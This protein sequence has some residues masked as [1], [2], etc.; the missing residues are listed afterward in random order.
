MA[1]CSVV[2]VQ[3]TANQPMERQVF[4][5]NVFFN[6]P[7]GPQLSIPHRLMDM[8]IERNPRVH[9]RLHQDNFYRLNNWT[10]FSELKH[11]FALHSEAFLHPDLTLV[12]RVR[13]AILLSQ[14]HSFSF[15]LTYFSMVSAACGSVSG[16]SVLCHSLYVYPK[17]DTLH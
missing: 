15:T 12:H 4:K 2:T 16:F 1:L 5:P 7:F 14:H 3:D 13:M 6:Y 9:L 11:C 10:E 8:R 17:M